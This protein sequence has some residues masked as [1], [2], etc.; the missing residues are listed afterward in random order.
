MA[1][2]ENEFF[3][4]AT[5][6]LC[7]TLDIEKAIDRCRRYLERYF[8]ITRIDLNL[9]EPGLR[10]MRYIA[11]S[12]RYEKQKIQS[13]IPL[14]EEART[15]IKQ[16]LEERQDVIIINNPE[17][18]PVTRHLTQV[19]KNT[20]VSYMVMYLEIEG[21]K[22]GV[23]AIIAEGKGE[24]TKDHANLLSLLHDPF[25]IA[26]SNAL[27]YQ[28]VL[29]LKDLQAD[30]IRYLHR[31]LLRFSGDEI[32]GRDFGLKGVMEKVLQVAPLNSPVLLLGETGVGKEVIA[33]A[34]HYFSP[35]KEGP[36]IKINCGAIPEGLIDSELFGHEKGA[37]TG[38]IAKRRGLFERANQGTFFLDEIGELP[39]Q[40]Q[41]RLLR[42]LQ[43]HEIKSVGGTESIPVDIRIIVATHRNL[44]EMVASQRFR[45]DLLFRINVFPI[46]IPALRE[47][48][49]DIHALVRHFVERKSEEMKLSAI[50]S[51]SS[52]AIEILKCYDW[53]GNVRELENLVERALIQHRG[54]N[55]NGPLGL[56]ELSPLKIELRKMQ[57]PPREED[58]ILKLDEAMAIHIKRALKITK[59]KIEGPG[60]A[61]ER[62]GINSSTLRGRMDKLGIPYKKKESRDKRAF[63]GLA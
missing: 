22:L 51:I 50:P 16:E 54:H 32:I 4:Q 60:G 44:E 47:R 11:Q 57:E 25:A 59:G 24:F 63:L 26:M 37:F 58:E 6:R 48:K 27:R 10:S 62:L 2:D 61:S 18:N 1:A 14:S 56:E 36:F 53:P 33:N 39:A 13:V 35:R 12:T 49:E 55:R 20:G 41:T 7:G 19:T 5:L 8:P 52:E 46:T 28:E 42:V 45:Q 43:N 15:R 17:E 9:F 23:I 40:A 3:R 21:K 30:D 34:I 38:A 29:E 31:E